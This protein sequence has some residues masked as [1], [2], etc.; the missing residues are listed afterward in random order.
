MLDVIMAAVI[1]AL[2]WAL[3]RSAIKHRKDLEAIHDRL[4]RSHDHVAQAVVADLHRRLEWR[5]PSLDDEPETEAE[6]A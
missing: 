4:R 3:I 1:L 6:N 2:S 5:T